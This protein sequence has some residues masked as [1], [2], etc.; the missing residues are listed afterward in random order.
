MNSAS[1]IREKT[2]F[3]T[4]YTPGEEGRT[5]NPENVEMNW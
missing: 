2:P 5:E 3:L 4:F 1:Y